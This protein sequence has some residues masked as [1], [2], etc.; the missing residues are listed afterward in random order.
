MKNSFITLLKD[1]SYMS[2]W[3]AT[4]FSMAASNILQFTLALYVLELTGSP[5]IYASILSIVVIPRILLTPI[6]GVIADRYRRLHVM[7]LINFI[8]MSLLMAYT[9]FSYANE[10]NIA[11]YLLY[12]LVVALEIIEVFY[13]AP[14]SAILPEIIEQELISEAVLL[15]KID[16]GIVFAQRL[17]WAHFFTRYLE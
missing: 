10:G 1:R 6:S 14:E 11:L 5:T 17:Y 15:S 2:Y 4:T 8:S 12:I 7:R 9:I 16:D 13:Q 3:F